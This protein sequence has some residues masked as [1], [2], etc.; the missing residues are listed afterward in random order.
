MEYK[1]QTFNIPEVEG[2]S[3]KTIDE[4]LKL[5]AGYV[6]HANIITATIAEMN[7]YTGPDMPMPAGTIYAINEMRRRFSFEFNGM[8]NHE[9]YFEQLEGGPSMGNPESALAQQMKK[10]FGSAEVWFEEFKNICL[11]RGIGWAILYYDKKTDSLVNAWVDEQHLGQL[12]GLDFIYGVD[13]WEHSYYL[14]YTPAEKKKY[15][16][17]YLLATNQDVVEKRFEKIKNS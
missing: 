1:E 16:E 5:Y 2:I 15:V 11:T 6:K 4:H 9:Y 13:M 14:D 10:D 8:R 12:N 7:K 17:S 3:K